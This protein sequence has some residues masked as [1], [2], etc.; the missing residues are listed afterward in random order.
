ML[1]KVRT[2][3]ALVLQGSINF[4][5]LKPT[6]EAPS[7]ENNKDVGHDITIVERVDNRSEDV[8]GDVNIFSTGLV[9]TAP[10]H[11]HIEII[12]HPNLYKTGYMLAGGPRI[13]NP[14]SSEELILPLYKFKETEDIE[15]PFRAALMVLRETEY[16]AVVAEPV[17]KEYDRYND[18]RYRDEDR[19]QVSRGGGTSSR[20]RPT[21]SSQTVKSKPPSK[22]ATHMF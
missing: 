2:G 10:L 22:G 21:T 19:R 4:V 17:K 5:K 16:C 7:K 13:I 11:Y 9:L 15:L 1:S 12:E 18:D 8:Y 20:S 14:G 6:A 3:E